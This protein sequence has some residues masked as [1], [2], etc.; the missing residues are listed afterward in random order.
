MRDYYKVSLLHAHVKICCVN[1]YILYYCVHFNGLNMKVSKVAVV[2]KMEDFFIGLPFQACRRKSCKSFT[3][4]GGVRD[5][6]LL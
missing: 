1:V 4:D 3:H 5:P 2:E 6:K